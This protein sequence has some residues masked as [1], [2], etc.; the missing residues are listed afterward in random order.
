MKESGFDPNLCLG[1]PTRE[2]VAC[3][4][5]VT[6]SRGFVSVFAFQPRGTESR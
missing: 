3:S 6:V 1:Y 2:K 5:P 4:R